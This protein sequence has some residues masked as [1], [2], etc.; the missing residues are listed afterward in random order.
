MFSSCQET[1]QIYISSTLVDCIGIAPQKCMLYKESLTDEWT[2]FYDT[3]DGFEYE[4]GYDYEIEVVVTKIENP[5]ADSSSLHYTFVKTI[6]KEKNPSIAQNVPNLAEENQNDDIIN[7][8]YQAF[9]RGSFFLVKIN[10]GY[11]EKTSDR[12][13]KNSV[14]K[15]CPK[16]DWV[17][18]L[19]LIKN[20]DLEKIKEFIPPSDRRASDAARH[21]QLIIYSETK[22][23]TSTYFDHGNPPKEIQQLVNTILSLAESIE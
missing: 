3:I 7:I 18:I 22:T 20:I 19:H 9:S 11:I 12:S 21:G 15:K 14:S 8:T 16:E 2:Y 17:T 4:E 1:K 10:K 13:F 23:F 5:P 6:S